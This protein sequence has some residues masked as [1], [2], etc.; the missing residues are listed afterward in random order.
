ML[1]SIEIQ[2]REIRQSIL[3]LLYAMHYR[4]THSGALL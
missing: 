4:N 1:K 3:K 2:S